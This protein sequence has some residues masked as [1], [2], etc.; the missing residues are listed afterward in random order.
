MQKTITQ[1][2]PNSEMSRM[3]QEMLAQQPTTELIP[4]SVGKIDIR[5]VRVLERRSLGVVDEARQAGVPIEYL[6]QQQL[7]T[8]PRLY[9]GDTN[10]WIL[11]PATRDEDLVV[12]KPEQAVLQR[13]ANADVEFPMIYVAHEIPKAKT[14]ELVRSTD[15]V[16]TDIEHCQAN[17][18]IGPVPEPI[19]SVKLGQNLAQ[20][21]G[22]VLTTVR[23]TAIAGG[24][25]VVA[26]AAAPVVLAGAALAGVAQL[27]PIIL[28]A[29]PAGEPRDGEIAAFFVLARWDW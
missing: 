13:L 27:D 3:L 19:E 2:A 26:I 8:K 24:G 9:D 17:E 12:P 7:F 25:A 11:G 14:M 29:I 18:L 1:P 15:T 4:R 22:K 23:K 10:D 5:R 16:H 28:G 20:R 6:G 21:S